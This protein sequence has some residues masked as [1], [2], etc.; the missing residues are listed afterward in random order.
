MLSLSLYQNTDIFFTD[1]VTVQ[2]LMK[3]S[4]MSF[5]LTMIFIHGSTAFTAVNT[6]EDD[7]ADSK[8]IAVG[9]TEVRLGSGCLRG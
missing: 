9:M 5:I 2:L 3:M 8:V 4:P 7:D 1:K 6:E